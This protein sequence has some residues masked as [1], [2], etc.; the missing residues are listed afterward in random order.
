MPSIA[1]QAEATAYENVRSHPFTRIHGRPTRQGFNTLKEEV[2]MLAC[3]VEDIN[4]PWS[5]DATGEYGLLGEIIGAAEYDHLT[6][7]STYA[8]PTEPAVYDMTITNAIAT[9]KLKQKE[10]EWERTLTSWYI[11]KGFLKGVVENM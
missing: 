3:E 5:K 9:H 7:I 11:C 1:K 2:P 6:G 10:E 8:K 4:Y